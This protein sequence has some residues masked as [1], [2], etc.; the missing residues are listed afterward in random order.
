MKNLIIAII[1]A[2]LV[3]PVFA[4]DTNAS[5]Y[6]SL[7][8]SMSS[9]LSYSS[10]RLQNFDQEIV[11]N[12]QGKSY[13]T[14]RIRYEAL[15]KALED[16]EFKLGRLIEFH[17]TPVKIKAERDRYESLVMQLEDIKSEYDRWM[18]QVQ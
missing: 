8:D 5:L 7:N 15:T 18:R 1:L 12:N 13:S 14:Y 6:R 9:T 3:V 11:Y 4:Q 16:S 2:G 10:T 17:D